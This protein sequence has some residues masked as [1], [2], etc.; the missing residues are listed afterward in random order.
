[1]VEGLR[2]PWGEGRALRS[3][4]LSLRGSVSSAGHGLA[5]RAFACPGRRK[6][7]ALRPGAF[8]LRGSAAPSE[9]A[10]AC[11]AG[12]L[13][14]RERRFYDPNFI[15]SGFFMFSFFRR[16]ITAKIMLGVLG[17]S[18]FA[19]V[20]TGFGT[21]GMGGLGE[22][23]S[24][25]LGADTV[26]TVGGEKITT[27]RVRDE[28]NRALDRMR[29]QQPTIDMAAFIRHGALNELVD[30]LIGLSAAVSFGEA[31]G[32]VA[33]KRMVDKVIAGIPA[34]QGPTGQFDQ[35]TFLGA[36]NRNKMTEQQ[37]RDQIRT[38][39]IQR[40]LMLPAAGTPF[41]PLGIAGPYASLLLES[42]SG[43]VGAVPTKAIN[44]GTPPG[45]AEVAA[46]F[47]HNIARYTIPERRVIRYAA[48]G[49]ENVAARSQAT[50]AEIAAAYARNPA[51]QSRE[52]RTLSQV[53]LPDEKAARAF[54]QKVAAGTAFAQAAQQAGFSA[55]DIAVG[56]KGK[57]E[58]ARIS[59]PQVATAA[60]AAAKGA[61]IGP[62]RS[63]LGWHVVRIDDVKTNPGKPLA[64]VRAELAAGIARDKGAAALSDM[65]SR[66]DTQVG[67]G[68]AFADVVKA[69]KLT[70]VETPPITA[71]GQAPDAPAGWTAGPDLAPILQGAFQL[72]PSDAP[73]V[74][75]VVPNQR[76]AL[77]AVTRVVPA[78][79]PPLAQIRDRVRIDLMA[80]RASDRG[81]AIAQSIVSKINAGVPPAQAFAQA[82]IA[83]P[84]TQ[85]ITATR[86][87][88]A[89]Q[90]QQVAPP[91][92]M[93]FSLPRGKARLLAAADARGWFIVYLDKIVPGDAS[94][95]PELP[96]AVRGQLAQILSDEYAQ[97]FTGAI[98]GG[99]TEKRNDK[100][101]AKL[102]ASMLGAGPAQ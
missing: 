8:A 64:A 89:R 25:S 66:I 57:D 50:D 7:R 6:G 55:T 98:R 87:E 27:D 12:M 49:T 40:Q 54:A 45:D 10:H 97:Q 41:V 31:H 16:G 44:P 90:G 35:N 70:V 26:A 67:G 102:R 82:G 5:P 47:Q 76:F 100:A 94:T 74:Q 2:K 77:V 24:G 9:V 69:E 83:L 52:V 23:A 85:A 84:P 4:V 42:R 62:I 37:L 22:L 15:R 61:T 81:H 71:N 58:F 38:Q 72:E 21:G 14:R 65:A 43:I 75:T 3:G 29:Q 46:Y 36:L 56:D 91:L 88:I 17:L 18:L 80:Q 99:M 48:F 33:T 39:L 93:L 51:Y 53:V 59:S 32:L 96:R 30:Q 63:G 68:A 11:S 86:Q 101:L 78:A 28:A 79:A 95:K 13:A 92:A 60:F 34:F 19:I 73:A 20:I 1:M